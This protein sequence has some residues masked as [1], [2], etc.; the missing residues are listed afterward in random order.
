MCRGG[1][2]RREHLC[3][4][5]GCTHTTAQEKTLQCACVHPGVYMREPT[6]RTRCALEHNLSC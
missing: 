4:I 6:W 5:Y 3:T 1:M 2:L